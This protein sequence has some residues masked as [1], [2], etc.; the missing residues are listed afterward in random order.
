MLCNNSDAFG[1]FGIGVWIVGKWLNEFP[2]KAGR[3]L[4]E[5]QIRLLSRYCIYIVSI[6]VRVKMVVIKSDIS[7]LVGLFLLFRFGVALVAS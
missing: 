3:K 4:I 1:T 2:G 7:T 6:S 5:E